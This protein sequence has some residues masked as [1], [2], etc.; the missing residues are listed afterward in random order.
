M[1]R[2]C[3]NVCVNSSR[4]KYRNIKYSYNNVSSPKVHCFIIC[5]IRKIFRKPIIIDLLQHTLNKI[6]FI[7]E[8]TIGYNTWVLAWLLHDLNTEVDTNSVSVT[9]FVTI[10]IHTICTRTAISTTK[11]IHKFTT[12]V[13]TLCA[14]RTLTS[15][16]AAA[17]NGQTT[18]AT[19]SL[20]HAIA[21]LVM[22]TGQ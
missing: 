18:E 15:N 22:H 16:T 5:K 21:T 3:T 17:T 4:W 12:R 13:P 11:G 19:S 2:V 7:F 9:V 6:C 20:T 14:S 10:A 8:D 1:R